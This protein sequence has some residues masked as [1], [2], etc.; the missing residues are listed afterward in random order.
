VRL[1][2]AGGGTGGHLFPGIAIADEVVRRGG[3]E[4]LFV[5]TSRGIEIRAVPT[6]GYALETLTVSG[7]KR[8]GLAGTLR[9]LF[10]LP[11]AMAKSLSILRRF[12]PDIV[13]GVGG[14]ASGPM[15]LAAALLGYP[16]AIQESPTGFWASWFLP[17][18]SRSKT[19]LGFSPRG[20]LNA[21]AIP[22]GGRL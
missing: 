13:V 18:S 22:C 19:P 3:G 10:R 16:T 2:V 20:R 9:G 5:G 6:A 8:M 1:L 15:M 12:R 14:Y 21:L 11:V 17:C 7:L 4:V